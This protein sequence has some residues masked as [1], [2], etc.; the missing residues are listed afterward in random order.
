MLLKPNK[1]MTI[2]YQL[3]NRNRHLN[4]I[5]LTSRELTCSVSQQAGITTQ[6]SNLQHWPI[7]PNREFKE[8]EPCK[9]ED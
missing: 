3:F 2:C 6:A 7:A 8:D 1:T 9:T 5:F 4:H